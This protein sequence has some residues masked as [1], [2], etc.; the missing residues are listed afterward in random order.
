MSM[1]FCL[2]CRG[3]IWLEP[4][5]NE[6]YCETCAPKEF[7]ETFKCEE[8]DGRFHLNA[9]HICGYC[10]KYICDNCWKEHWEEDSHVAWIAFEEV[11][12]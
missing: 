11:E 2:K 8:C 4:S 9:A 1:G 6:N 12:A 5:D 10:S 3:P 7:D